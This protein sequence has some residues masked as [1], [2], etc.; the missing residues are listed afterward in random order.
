[1]RHLGYWN[2]GLTESYGEIAKKHA[3]MQGI[4]QETLLG[5]FPVI[6]FKNYDD[7]PEVY[8][9]AWGSTTWTPD[10]M[11]YG[12]AGPLYSSNLSN[13]HGD[14]KFNPVFGWNIDRAVQAQAL[15]GGD[16]DFSVFPQDES[17]A[18]AITKDDLTQDDKPYGVDWRVGNDAYGYNL[19]PEQ[20]SLAYLFDPDSRVGG[21]QSYANVTG[22]FQIDDEGYYYY[23]MRRNF[24]EFVDQPGADKEGK[25]SDG[26]FVLYNKPAGLRTDGKTT[27]DTTADPGEPSIGNFFP[28]NKGTEVFKIVDGELQNA[29]RADN[30]Q[31]GKTGDAVVGNDGVLIDHHLGMTIET[32]FRQPIDGEVAG[33][34]MTFEFV[35]DDDMWVFID[36]VLVLDLGGIHS[37]LYGTIDYSTGEIAWGTAFNSNGEIFDEEGE[38]ITTPVDTTTIKAQFEKAGKLGNE[39]D[40][41]GNTFASNTSHTLKMFYLERGNYDSSLS[42]K[43]NLQPALYQQ[44]KKVDQNGKPLQNAEFALYALTTPEGITTDNA[45]TVT[46]AG[47][48]DQV[49][50]ITSDTT[51]YATLKT[52]ANGEAIFEQSNGEP[53]NFSDEYTREN[54]RGLLYLLREVNPPD[55]YKKAPEDILLRFN[56]E[57]TM[58]IVNNRYTTGA[59]VSFNSYVTG[60]TA[61]VSYGTLKEDGVVEKAEH[62]DASD[63]EGGLVVAI[64]LLKSGEKW[65]AL[66]GSNLTGFETVE[67]AGTSGDALLEAAL[68]QAAL[69]ANPANEG[70][71]NGWY[72][73][74]D[75]ETRR[76]KGTLSNL[77]GRADRYQLID[78]EQG[79]M[80]MV[81]AI[82]EPEALEKVIVDPS[83]MTG[84][85]RYA[86]LG[87]AVKDQGLEVVKNLI[88]ADTGARALDMESFDRNF[89][90][91]IY[92]PNEVRQLRVQKI[93]Q[94]GKPVNGAE[95]TLYEDPECTKV[96]ATGETA[97]VGGQD[98]I[99]LF[100]PHANHSEHEGEKVDGHAD[101]TWP[102]VPIDTPS[103]K[104]PTYY[105]KETKAPTNPDGTELYEPYNGT[106]VVKVGTYSI[107][108]DAGEEGDG[109]TVMAGVGKLTQTM[110]KYTAKN[111]NVT[112]RDIVAHA[113]VQSSADEFSLTVSE[114][115]DEPGWRP[116]Q[117]EGT[118]IDR[119][120]NLAYKNGNQ[121]ID[122]GLSNDNGGQYINPFFVTDTGFIRAAVTQDPNA[123][124]DGVNWEDLSDNASVQADGGYI[125]GLF[126]LV[127]TVVVTN[128]TTM[129]T[130]TGT[131]TISKMVE[132]QNL[133]DSDRTR[134]FHFKIVLKD[135]NGNELQGQYYYYGKDRAGY[136]QSGVPEE[137]LPFHHDDTIVILGLPEGTT[138]EITEVDANEYGF[139]AKPLS[140][141]ITGVIQADP[142]DDADDANGVDS[143]PT[144]APAVTDEPAEGGDQTQGDQGQADPAIQGRDTVDEVAG[145]SVNKAEFVNVKGN[146][147]VTIEKLQ[148]VGSSEASNQGVNP[149]DA[150]AVAAEGANVPGDAGA[151]AG[152]DSVPAAVPATDPAAEP[153][154]DDEGF[155]KELLTVVS[156][157]IVTYKLVVENKSDMV[158]KGIVVTD[159][160]PEGLTYIPGTA[161]IRGLTDK[162]NEDKVTVSK[163]T[164]GPNVGRTSIV[165]EIGDLNPIEWNADHPGDLTQAKIDQRIVEF[166]V[167]VP[168]ITEYR[169]WDNHGI[170]KY[171]NNPDGPN[172]EIPSN[173]VEI[174]GNV[175]AGFAFTKLVENSGA[176]SVIPEDLI[177]ETRFPF[178]VR[179]WKT[180][181]A[182]ASQ[183]TPVSGE[184]L[185]TITK[186][187]IVTDETTGETSATVGSTEPAP[188]FF[189]EDGTFDYLLDAVGDKVRELT[190]VAGETITIF[191]L[192]ADAQFE[193]TEDLMGGALSGWKV[194]EPENG[195]ATG[196][197]SS[198]KVA[199]D[200]S[201]IEDSLVAADAAAPVDATAGEG[202]GLTD[203][204]VCAAPTALI[205]RAAVQAF[206][207][208]VFKNTV[209]PALK[210]YKGQRVVDK[211]LEGAESTLTGLA[212]FSQDVQQVTSGDVVEYRLVVTNASAV[213]INN[214]SVTDMLPPQEPFLTYVDGSSTIED[215]VTEGVG[216]PVAVEPTPNEDG[217]SLTW[218]VGNLAPGALKAITFRMLV[219]TVEGAHTWVNYGTATYP[220]NPD[221]PEKSEEVEVESAV[222][223]FAITKKTVVVDG[224]DFAP[225]SFPLTVKL[226]TIIDE[227]AIPVQGT[228]HYVRFAE[229]G[230]A[231][232]ATDIEFGE[233]GVSLTAL[234]IA[235]NETISIYGL[236]RDTQYEVAET[237]VG[238][239]QQ[240]PESASITGVAQLVSVPEATEGTDIPTIG[241]IVGQL[242]KKEFTNGLPYLK[243]EKWQRVENGRNVGPFDP[244]GFSQTEQTVTSGDVVTY[245]LVV[246][247][248]SEVDAQGVSITDPMP[249][250]NPRLTYVPDSAAIA[251]VEPA[252]GAI[253]LVL[254]E[255]GTTVTGITW[256]LGTLPAGGTQAVTFQVKVPSI[257]DK[258]E[259]VNKGSAAYDNNP[260]PSTPIES[261]EVVIEGRPGTPQIE[262]H[263][264]QAFATAPGEGVAPEAYVQTP[265][266]AEMG[267]TV[268][269]KLV[270]SNNADTDAL[271]VV[272][273]DKVPV[274]SAGE[275][276]PALTYKGASPEAAVKDGVLAWNLGTLAA[277]ETR[278]VFF[279]VEVPTVT[280]DTVWPN[281]ATV[282][283][284]NDDPDNPPDPSEEVE[285]KTP[286][287]HLTIEKLHRVGD[288]AEFTKDKLDVEAGSVV[289]YELVVRN[290][291]DASAKGVQ[292]SDVVPVSATENGPAYAYLPDGTWGVVL[293]ADG[294]DTGREVG[295][296]GPDMTT[297]RA[298][299]WTTAVL[300]P[301][302]QLVVG[303]QVQVPRVKEYTQWKNIGTV[304]YNNNPDNPTDP[305]RPK[306]EEPSNPVEEETD[307]P[308]VV[309]EKLQ[310]T[311]TYKDGELTVETLDVP[312][313]AEVTY[314][315]K[316]TN[317]SKKIARGVVV[318]DKLPVSGAEAGN[319]AVQLV[320]GSVSDGGTCS[321]DGVVQWPAF[322]LEPGVSRVVTF[323]VMVPRVAQATSWVN[324]A[325]FAYDNNPNN[326]DD[327]DQ[328]K[329]E[330]PSNEVEVDTDVTGLLVS[331]T[332]V[333]PEG[334]ADDGSAVF[335]FDVTVAAADGKPV[336][337]SYFMARATEKDEAG[338]WVFGEP[339]PVQFA[340]GRPVLA[341][342]APLTLRNLEAV[343]FIGLPE[344][345][346]YQ[347]VETPADGW[348]QTKA[349]NAEGSLTT[350]ATVEAAFTNTKDYGPAHLAIDGSK[351]MTG[352]PFAAGAF[353]F[354][355][356]PGNDQTQKAVEEG[357]VV[358]PESL[359]TTNGDPVQFED[360][361]AA[362]SAPWTFGEIVF[363]RAGDY[364]FKVTERVPA[365]AEN[366]RPVNGVRYDTVT[367]VV[368]VNV[369]PGTEG[370]LVATKKLVNATDADA[371]IVFTNAYAG[372]RVMVPIAGVKVLEGRELQAGE[373][374]FQLVSG[375][376]ENE[377]VIAVTNN[378][379]GIFAF[380][381]NAL[382][383]TV[384]DLADVAPAADGTRTKEFFYVV[385]ELVPDDKY[386]LPGVTYDPARYL[387]KVTLTDN[388]QGVLSAVPTVTLEGAEGAVDSMVFS[389]AYA[390]QG[391]AEAVLQVGKVLTGRPIN[392]NEFSFTAVDLATGRVVA[393]GIAP[394]T[395][396]GTPV[397]VSLEKI[398]YDAASMADAE[399]Y[400]D[401]TRGKAFTYEIAENVGNLPLVTYDRT[402]YYARVWV[403]DDGL[404]QMTASAPAYF[405][406]MACEQ[407]VEGNWPVFR[408]AYDA[409][410]A[411]YTP[412]AYKSTWGPED[413][414]LTG[415]SFGFEVTDNNGGDAQGSVVAR[416]MAN[417]N[418]PVVFDK[419]LE[420]SAAGT[421]H[422]VLTE[423]N[424]GA[425]SVTYDT[426][427]Y[428]LDVTVGFNEAGGLAVTEAVYRNVDGTE[429][430]DEWGN[431]LA[432]VF[433][434][435]FSGKG[436]FLNLRAHKQLVD[437]NGNPLALKPGAFSFSVI[438]EA[439]GE[440]VSWGVNDAA[441]NVSFRTIVYSYDNIVPEPAVVEEPVEVV[442]PVEPAAPVESEQPGESAGSIDPGVPVE[443]AP[444]PDP[445]QPGDPGVPGEPTVPEQP[446][447]PE[448]P[449]EPEGPAEPLEPEAPSEE[450]GGSE[451]AGAP[452]GLE[453]GEGLIE[454]LLAPEV[455]VADDAGAMPYVS[456]AVPAAP[457]L[458]SSALGKHSYLIMED[459]PLGAYQNPDGSW[460]YNGVTYERD[461][462]RVVVDVHENDQKNAM[463]A[464]IERID[465]L[466][467]GDSDRA[468]PVTMEGF[469]GMDH[470]VFENVERPAE[471]P[472]VKLE[473]TK[474]LT[475]RAME[476]EEFGFEVL[477]AAGERVAAGVS[478]A[479]ADGQ[480]S[481]IAFAEFAVPAKPGTY[482]YTVREVS[483]GQEIAGVTFSTQVFTVQV[484][485]AAN[486]DGTLSSTV[487]YPDGPV[488]FVNT[489][490]PEGPAEVKLEGTKTLVGRAM[491][492]NEFS[493]A[494][495]DVASGKMLAGG[496]SGA[497]ANGEAAA[498]DF[499]TIA[500]TQAGE[501]DL[502]VVETPPFGSTAGVAYDGARFGVHVSVTDAGAGKLA[503]AVSYPDG[504][505]AFKNTYQAAPVE[506]VLGA[507]KTLEGRE[508]TH[509]AF[510][511]TVTDANGALAA[512]GV[513]LADGSVAFGALRF[514]SAGT[515]T[516]TIAEVVG[517]EAGMTYDR[518]A[519]TAVV[520]VTDDGEGNLLASV[521]YP[522]GSPVFANR[523]EKPEEPPTPDKP[524]P[525]TPDTPTP[526]KPGTPGSNVPQTGDGTP[527]WT[528]PLAAIGGALVALAGAVLA[529]LR[530]R[531]RDGAR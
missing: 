430:V 316:V 379:Q 436:T 242:T 412:E 457:V 294:T 4:V 60:N 330:E 239:W 203:E 147:F 341:D 85:Q 228:F 250:Q 411:S 273:T 443:P 323:K 188:I 289:E 49:A 32:D 128:Q 178:N 230:T 101:V 362:W 297:D 321:E 325:K 324:Q 109:V 364:E 36:D 249:I 113:Q 165:W 520:D 14:P 212:G 248:P 51:P 376:G 456:E 465:R 433:Q 487:A 327:P 187:T 459:V 12:N 315:I 355:L 290:D 213:T 423:R 524:T 422:Y 190:L 144:T 519:Y 382:T 370:S 149:R 211:Q 83:N 66:T 394:A 390:Y 268:I 127:N 55:G 47:V 471:P 486:S 143:A 82:I 5:G 198:F 313:Y 57:T 50:A 266:V 363:N 223:G 218:Q 500:F 235:P 404:G 291:S 24:A 333:V 309:I 245:K 246:S 26:H 167:R 402:R 451:G 157:D 269:Y 251:G 507:T 284:D 158:A 476:A 448:G 180:D 96:V 380:P 414:D 530:L 139:Y 378:G 53:C 479:A 475:G 257:T 452:E 25:P 259:W 480:P 371:P 224:Q 215:V 124:P 335:A 56:P 346:T 166:Q 435:S 110:V 86:A 135:E 255:A 68:R 267:S 29:V 262:I 184:F 28:F 272:V 189:K 136:I 201:V 470:V 438:D 432:P 447:E 9:T 256:N 401:G 303:F 138:Y 418:G 307:V 474:T 30:A 319:V 357:A 521:T 229:D 275:G 76:L 241:E 121:V 19:T 409:P 161:K 114:K 428:L 23:N 489:Y 260:D 11:F 237:A 488:A 1:M 160:V 61:T 306:H 383:Y 63:Q 434:N 372:D 67:G 506:V 302:E 145:R 202:V 48:A 522:D 374:T 185:Y 301:G 276:S 322:D 17:E 70:I 206:E 7:N 263:K 296:S 93:D 419:A 115:E 365:G 351:V 503:A 107:Y 389:N 182:D 403:V 460:T 329:P 490:T 426:A 181:G 439:T 39:S 279:W 354:V 458:T 87:Q 40:W 481:Q 94:N 314:Q 493:F 450:Q 311:P 152:T 358:L 116:D 134:N 442:E 22:L 6:N 406:D 192:P 496:A 45:D 310:G 285:V 177:A 339:E 384:A 308:H 377:R 286:V 511:F 396:D 512:E 468:V 392:S 381:A 216:E 62:V 440:R 425:P 174:E 150:G 27:P 515:Y 69:V 485:V 484:T 387:V 397:S 526:G 148:K 155:T 8:N 80:R 265:L 54:G 368:D 194:V 170:L 441:G 280:Q 287:P 509:G 34:P 375:E 186:S 44:I 141:V 163:I 463:V 183:Q 131:L 348:T 502:V 171:E 132:G 2:Q 31:S 367:R 226:W 232:A 18:A 454:A 407:P 97:P 220:D 43:F 84:A 523:Y 15:A 208:V 331:K 366:G 492:A 72:L 347:V 344:K 299:T 373:F 455:A 117:L 472:V 478:G 469:D 140:G 398:T 137:G 35:G 222:A 129:P 288:T 318:S 497:A 142:V 146:P 420:F 74:W 214:V 99:L 405:W 466:E 518:R 385:R 153:T 369:S 179:V 253:Q 293:T 42:I 338:A 529:W 494:V 120:M 399:Q 243:I 417:A 95:F 108:A 118:N 424:N 207:P 501:Y 353:T 217:K 221:E 437:G 88:G 400:E 90:S 415:L 514:E 317:D 233:D 283:S 334:V 359:E 64:P 52:D 58:F 445:E 199:R 193:I 123:N 205:A 231:G 513:N 453:G 112:L 133:T 219:P 173:E 258:S 343:R 264:Y 247:N 337:G 154:V 410:K 176:N 300:Q 413:A 516:Y 527:G 98:G 162:E 393:T 531:T 92:I 100:E 126:S 20:R 312:A 495:Y 304:S 504:P 130:K 491:E 71:V 175:V 197:V 444:G 168:S 449:V 517:T 111:V 345:A 254:D 391:T 326:P 281:V 191:G 196:D 104:I 125:T 252:D 270:V 77:P 244:D 282:T 510:R 305:E 13:T 238:V 156:N 498:I 200:G 340:D 159:L 105:L 499:A 274:P 477:D 3:G 172:K 505:V 332:A 236:P 225:V 350:G 342:S 467:D 271:N 73:E 328:P 483:E 21:K 106:I 169:H 408:N 119:T 464:T 295:I 298:I 349:E 395:A 446:G 528:A 240:L 37:E 416:G 336:A 102:N 462:Y 75:T 46:L 195:V 16:F 508:L 360:G 352:R 91:V 277:H 79:D 10:G 427:A 473:G 292:V 320:E 204:S 65:I 164:S 431:R 33:K 356:A 361:S 525:G 234:S 59:Y 38:Y 41:N 122:Y 89:R 278:E 151:N 386:A 388:G 209:P 78:K 482:V 103:E 461:V 429:L 227:S 81:Y 421:Y 261:N 210:I